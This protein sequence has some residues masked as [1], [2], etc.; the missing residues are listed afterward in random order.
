[1][2]RFLGVLATNLILSGDNAVVIAMA[3]RRLRGSQRKKAI[4]W[5]AAGAVGLR[6][7]FALVITFL[8]AIPFVQVAGGL[9]LFWI[10]WQLVRSGEDD[11]DE[12]KVRAGRSVWDAVKIIIAADAVMSLDNVI[13]L[14][15]VSGGNLWLL[16]IGLA[17]TIPLVVWGATLLSA[18]LDRWPILVYA[19]AGLLAWVALGM[20]FEEEAIHGILAGLPNGFELGAKLAGTGIFVAF[21][22]LWPFGGYS[23]RSGSSYSRDQNGWTVVR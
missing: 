6:M 3:G 5:G 22:W 18:L 2:A 19:G 10:A 12:E 11:E 8:L 9:L 21:V 20:I 7:V 17:L 1:M 13:A 4:F 23:G 15:G 14:V 16:G